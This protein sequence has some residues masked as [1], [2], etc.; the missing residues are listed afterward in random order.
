MDYLQHSLISYQRGSDKLNGRSNAI[1]A[2]QAKALSK[3]DIRNIAEY[4][5]SLPG[6]L[7]IRK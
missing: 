7:V 3:E 1:M 5:H 6:T 2:A 4:I